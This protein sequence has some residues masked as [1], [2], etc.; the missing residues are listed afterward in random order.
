LL[1]LTTALPQTYI[2]SV[3]QFP[4]PEVVPVIGYEENKDDDDDD[5]QA[6]DSQ[7]DSVATR[8]FHVTEIF[9]FARTMQ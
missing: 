3:R 2:H 6:T 1:S 8:S 7:T 4:H 9:L 5:G